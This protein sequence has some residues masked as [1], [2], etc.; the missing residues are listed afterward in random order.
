M[1]GGDVDTT[2]FG[3][4]DDMGVVDES[5]TLTAVVTTSGADA[6]LACGADDGA[7]GLSISHGRIVAM[8][9]G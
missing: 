6:V 4:L 7:D 1:G 3:H 2:E 9:I 5:F 8:K